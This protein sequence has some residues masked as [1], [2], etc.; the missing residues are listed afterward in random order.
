VTEVKSSRP[1]VPLRRGFV[2][3]ADLSPR[4]HR[5]VH[6]WDRR[7]TFLLQLLL[8]RLLIVPGVGRVDDARDVQSTLGEVMWAVPP[9]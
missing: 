3:L 1:E 7:F 5:S 8:L 2:N 6:L 4:A 9:Q